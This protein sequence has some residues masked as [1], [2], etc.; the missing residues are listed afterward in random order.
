MKSKATR[1]VAAAVVL[2]TTIGIAAALHRML[3]ISNVMSPNG[4]DPF[5]SVFAQPPVL[6]FLHAASG[7]LFMV[8]GPLQFVRRIRFRHIAWHRWSGRVFLFSALLIGLTALRMAFLNPI[9]GLSEE[10]AAAIFRLAV[11]I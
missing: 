6:T 9:S 7:L 10:V 4:R 11:P 1:A 3:L 5:G 2:L 8:L